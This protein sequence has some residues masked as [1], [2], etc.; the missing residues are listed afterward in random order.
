[1]I[2]LREECIVPELAA[3]N[4][5]GALKE[6]TQ[7]LARFSGLD[8]TYLLRLINDREKVGSTGVGNG[9][10]IPHAKVGQLDRVLL[11]L[12]RSRD[13]ISFDAIDNQPVH[14]AVMILSPPD[15]PDEYLKILGKV[16]RLLKNPD[17]RKQ[18]RQATATT[19]IVG[20][21]ADAE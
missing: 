2:D 4:K 7:V 21:F 11:C 12:G 6:L 9:V 13:G 15:R 20:L 8:E 16:S 19:E 3:R 17:L 1:M 14:I 18:I 5:E 10:A